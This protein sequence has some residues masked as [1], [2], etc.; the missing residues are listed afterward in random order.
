MPLNIFRNFSVS[1][2]KWAQILTLWSTGVL[3]N[4]HWHCR[5]RK[6]S[7][8]CFQNIRQALRAASKSRNHNFTLTNGQL[9]TLFMRCSGC[10]CH[11][12][13]QLNIKCDKTNPCYLTKPNLDLIPVLK[14]LVSSVGTFFIENQPKNITFLIMLL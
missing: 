3:V 4:T 13:S 9:L 7:C 8:Y 14:P 1:N 5:N 6:P 2:P 10:L 12:N 11:A